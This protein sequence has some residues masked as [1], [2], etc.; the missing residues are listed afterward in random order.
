[1]SLIQRDKG[2]YVF[3]LKFFEIFYRERMNVLENVYR[4]KREKV[5][6]FEITKFSIYYL[7]LLFISRN[8]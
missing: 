2:E 5:F 4:N 3:S 6:P 7:K 8:T 1:M